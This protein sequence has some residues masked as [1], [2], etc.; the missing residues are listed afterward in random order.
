MINAQELRIGN[1][2]FETPYSGNS[3]V[4]EITQLRKNGACL[5]TEKKLEGEYSYESLS[6]I[7]LTEQILVEF[8]YSN[9]SSAGVNRTNFSTKSFALI[10]ACVII[11]VLLWLG[12]SSRFRFSLLCFELQL[13]FQRSFGCTLSH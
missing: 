13:S 5:T 12:N 8:G 10:S 3:I 9:S 7:P 1:L 6:P 2:V 11:Q 4:Y